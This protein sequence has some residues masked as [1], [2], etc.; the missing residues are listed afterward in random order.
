MENTRLANS[1]LEYIRKSRNSA[2]QTVKSY[3]YSLAQFVN[4]LSDRSIQDITLPEVDDYI[5]NRVSIST[6]KP[7]TIS[8]KN[9]EKTILRSFFRYVD[10]YLGLRLSFD[11]TMIRNYKTEVP[12][13]KFFEPQEIA[14]ILKKIKNP[15][16]R[17]IIKTFFATGMRI[18]ELIFFSV[19]DIRI[20]E[21]QIKGK[22]GKR[23]VVP[24]TDEF[25]RELMNF[26]SGNKISSGYVFRHI[27]DK[28]TVINPHYSS[29]GLRNR[30]KRILNKQGIEMNP[31]MFRH[32]IAT[33]LLT[34]GM[35]IR[36]VQVFLGHENIA[37]TMR[38]THIT[39]QHLRE[40]YLQSFPQMVL[41]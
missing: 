25:Y 5:D 27:M 23:R 4:F 26:I 36:S 9:T 2:D 33:A 13:T 37:T 16:D 7:L 18:S 39:D 29:N 12:R 30:L 21:I 32:S 28:K 20:G 22:G 14:N 40:S 8:S 35:D 17:M 24:I 38:Y 19:D 34:N 10:R 41:T 6:G 31:H 11:P 3:G 15:Q 1:Y